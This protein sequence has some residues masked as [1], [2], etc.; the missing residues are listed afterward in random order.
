MTM[1]GPCLPHLV[2][3]EDQHLL[4]VRKPA[5]WNTHAPSPH[6]GEGVYDWLRHR[7]PRWA[8][9]AII[10]RLD[11]ET[12]GV[13]AFANSPEANRSL[14]AQFEGRT[15]RKTYQLVTDRP[16]RP[17]GGQSPAEFTLVSTLERVGDR[18][19]SRPMRPG[20]DRAETRF[21]V[22][23][24]GEGTGLTRLE[25]EPVT[26]RTHQIRVHAAAA[27]FP[28]LGDTLYGGT[29]SGR[30][31]LH[32]AA[33]T[34]QHPVTH[35]EMT[36]A[37][38]A[39][40]G[41]DPRQALRRALQEWAPSGESLTTAWR[42]VHG[43]ADGWP[44][45]Q[46]EAL[47]EFLLS[48]SEHPLTEVQ[49]QALQGWLGGDPA[50]RGAYH[51]VLNRQ[52]RRT[53]P[54]AASPQHVLGEAAPPR[55]AILENGVRFELSFEEGYSVGLF[56]DQRDNRRRFRVGHVAA[57]FPLWAAPGSEPPEVL[58][59]FAYTC[60]FSVCAALGGAR[61]TSL[62]L[63]RKYLDWGR[64]NFAL[65][66]LDPAA[67]DFIYGDA[68]EWL[69]RLARKGRR[70]DAVVLDPPTFSQSKEGG[71]FRAEKD[72][73]RLAELALGVLKPGG[74]LLAS[75]NAATV[76]PEDFLQG[77]EEAVRSV[78]RRVAQRHYVPQP[79]DFPIT[80]EEPAHLKTAWLR[81]T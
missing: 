79:P 42:W 32:A 8:G 1:P 75:T 72:Y 7:E 48:Q 31:H 37:S 3:F 29:P 38:P 64:R 76:A 43:A 41:A 60:G 55:F 39:E 25:A 65:N 28:I 17:P 45:W 73:G 69:R 66:G 24:A 77:L 14:S 11:K 61:T 23:E 51:K 63:S 40:F 52:V 2:L 9:L 44:G 27:G 53:Q 74:V 19:E 15:V 46:V 16:V 22:V 13:L 54:G 4:V 50:R 80:R 78:G 56:L 33:L 12:S 18:Y 57:G 62:D 5:G 58:N 10:H 20:A 59:T 81:V 68:L 49:R 36:L 26:G 6:A 70:F 30:V 21:R 67:H 71:L 35:E 47:G 34:L